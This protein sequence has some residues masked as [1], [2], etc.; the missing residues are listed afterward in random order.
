LESAGANVEEARPD[1]LAMIPDINPKLN[2]GD[3]RAW[4]TRLLER[5]GT[6][7]MS[8]FIK[9]RLTQIDPVPSS[10]YSAMLEELDRYR[11]LMLGF[12][13]DYDAILC[14]TAAIPA[15]A[16]GGTWLDGNQWSFS[17]SG[18]YNMTGWPGAVV[19]GGTSP[20]GLPIGVQVVARP[21][22]EDVALALA[23]TLESAL[24]GWQKPKL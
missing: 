8:P 12:M 7:E 18:A 23:A 21:W 4:V 14:P 10:E 3:G 15:C 16:H 2:G 5:A 20:E 22:R 11:S 19:R 9:N 24:G 6:T 13:R 1:A 17:Y